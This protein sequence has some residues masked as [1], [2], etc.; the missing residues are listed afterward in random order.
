M[1][2]HPGGDTRQEEGGS[3]FFV[4]FVSG[5]LSDHSCFAKNKNGRERK[6]KEEKREG[7]ETSKETTH[8]QGRRGRDGM[9]G[10]M[11]F[12]SLLLAIDNCCCY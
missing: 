5:W 3:I 12:F 11:A 6:K 4:C 8:G 9:D 10:W 2:H 7:Q 1:R